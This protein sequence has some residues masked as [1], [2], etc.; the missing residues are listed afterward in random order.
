MIIDVASIGWLVSWDGIEDAGVLRV[1]PLWQSTSTIPPGRFSPP[2][3]ASD[4][5]VGAAR[6]HVHEVDVRRHR[7][8][9]L[10]GCVAHSPDQDLFLFEPLLVFRHVRVA[11]RV[12]GAD[13]LRHNRTA[14]LMTR[15]SKA[16]ADAEV[17]EKSK[18]VLERKCFWLSLELAELI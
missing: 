5:G 10:E 16:L 15:E 8:R 12:L 4:L 1:R 6:E 7:I 17:L 3:R 18:Y 13:H 14:D 11:D 9:R 2:R